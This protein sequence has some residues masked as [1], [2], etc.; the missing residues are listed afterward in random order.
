MQKP[1]PE[2][3][4]DEIPELDDEWF[5]R[6]KPAREVLPLS[7]QQKL[8]ML[9]TQPA[10][11]TVQLSHNVVERFRATGAGWQ[12]RIDAVLQD[13]LKTHSPG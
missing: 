1:N 12:T 11:D 10:T 2:L 6:A 4:D 7:L 9:D 3:I 5:A 8:G 13:W